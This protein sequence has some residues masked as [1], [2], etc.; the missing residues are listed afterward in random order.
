MI[1]TKINMG[2]EIPVH[3]NLGNA[4]RW[5]RPFALEVCT[6]EGYDIGCTTEEWSL[7]GSIPIDPVLNSKYND[8]NLPDGEVDY[9]FSSHC[10]EHCDNWVNTLRYWTSK[11]KSGG[12][13]FLYL[14][15][16]D[17]VSWRPWIN[18]SHNHILTPKYIEEFLNFEGIYR[19]IF[20]SQR[21]LNYS[22]AAMCE[23]E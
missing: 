14:P 5:I 13:L 18:F 21:D 9:I 3:V 22:F 4:S 20:V 1:E 12:V 15:H 19:K 23:K 10:L 6:G 7:P 11:L 2:Q 8:L 17:K 16:Y